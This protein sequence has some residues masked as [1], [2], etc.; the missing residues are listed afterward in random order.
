MVNNIY[1]NN[2]ESIGKIRKKAERFKSLLSSESKTI[3]MRNMHPIYLHVHRSCHTRLI[4]RNTFA[5]HLPIP[6]QTSK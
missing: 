1:C 3:E 6:L 4:I 2:K 5:N